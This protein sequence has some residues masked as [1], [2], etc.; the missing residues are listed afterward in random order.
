V[1]DA[2]IA[3][4]CLDHGVTELLTHDRDFCRVDGLRVIGFSGR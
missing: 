1:H 3:A 2:G 4:L